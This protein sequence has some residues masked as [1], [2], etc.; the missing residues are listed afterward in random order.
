MKVKLNLVDNQGNEYLPSPQDVIKFGLK[1]STD[2][3]EKPIIEK[4]ISSETMMLELT[5]ED[6]D[7]PPG[8]YL[9]DI[10]ITMTEK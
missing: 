4:I 1:S 9:Y 3:E 6:S 5:P 7:L 2:D 8:D 10:E